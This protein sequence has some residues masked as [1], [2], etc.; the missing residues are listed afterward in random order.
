MKNS[1]PLGFALLAT[2]LTIL[3]LVLAAALVPQRACGQGIPCPQVR[4]TSSVNCLN[5]QCMKAG[6]DVW[7]RCVR[8]NQSGD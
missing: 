1:T 3:G 7:G 6:T 5:C 2:G 4:C 8:F